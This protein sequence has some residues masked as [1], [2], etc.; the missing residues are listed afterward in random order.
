MLGK[1]G[2]TVRPAKGRGTV[3]RVTALSIFAVTVALVGQT[4]FSQERG[5][6]GDDDR[7]VTFEEDRTSTQSVVDTHPRPAP[8]PYERHWYLAVGASNYHPKL[9]ESEAKIDRQMNDLLGW[10]PAW[11]EPTT[12]K[13]WADDFKL[14]DLTL[15]V[16]RDITLRTSWMVW[17]GG[18]AATVKND[19]QYGLIST[20][21]RFSRATA[22]LTLEGYW[23]P[24]G[25][26]DYTT[27]EPAQGLGRFKTA[28][29]NAKPFLALGTGYTYVHCKADG[30]FKLPIMGTFMKQAE[31][32][33]HHMY[34]VSP[35]LGIEIPVSASNSVTAEGTYY[36]FG[37][38][39]ASEYNGPS[40]CIALKHRF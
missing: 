11:E 8:P 6:R 22:F 39:H 17:A 20:D 16:G 13:D 23:Y 40:F 21:I 36:F 15:A 31:K 37:P 4:A 29:G 9:E 32:Y 28:F 30:T 12:F 10:L 24:A 27:H 19:K 7:K 1:Q 25:K 14:W 38:A 33:D 5:G 26:V 34:Q 2:L 35:R 3:K 18:A